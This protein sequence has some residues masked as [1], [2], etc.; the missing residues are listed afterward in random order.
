MTTTAALT[1]NITT[2]AVNSALTRPITALPT[3]AHLI[4]F[5]TVSETIAPAAGG[6]A[7]PARP[8]PVG[9]T[10]T[11]GIARPFATPV[12][13]NEPSSDANNNGLAD[14]NNELVLASGDTYLTCVYDSS[15]TQTMSSWQRMTD[16]A[17]SLRDKQ[18]MDIMR[19]WDLEDGAWLQ[20]SPLVLRFELQDVVLEPAEN[21]ELRIWQGVLDDES[22][23]MLRAN[24]LP[25]GAHLTG[26]DRARLQ[27][28]RCRRNTGIAQA[29]WLAYQPLLQLVG[30]RTT[31]IDWLALGWRIAR[32]NHALADCLFTFSHALQQAC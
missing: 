16:L 29:C 2:I 9:T 6:M 19:G 5:P 15:A 8:L 22:D 32:R 26:A 31:M 23:C 27:R 21:G 24:W 17:Y 14:D 11:A 18:I 4:D 28:E 10:R 13:R 7:A 20:D 12:L 25:D 3:T 30:K 1:R